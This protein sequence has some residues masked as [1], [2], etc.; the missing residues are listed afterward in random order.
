M[1][2]IPR[3]IEPVVERRAENSNLVALPIEYI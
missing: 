1:Y 2:S 3:H